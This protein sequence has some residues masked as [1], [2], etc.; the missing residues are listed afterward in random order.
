MKKWEGYQRAIEENLLIVDKNQQEVP[1]KLNPAQLDF[2]KRSTD[3]NVI[4]KARKMGFSSVLLAVAVIKFIFGKNERC[5]SMSFDQGASGKQLERAK[6]FLDSYQRVNKVDFKLKYNSKY[7]MVMEV[8]NGDDSYTNT[9]RVGTA[10]SSGFGRGDDITFLHLTEVS[11]ADNIELLLAGVGEAVVNNAMIT[12]ETTA[13]G[14]NAFKT[15]WD[16]SAAKQRNYKAMFYAP[17]W[18]YSQEYLDKKKAE[19]GRLFDQEYPA[20]PELAFLTSGNTYFDLEALKW[21]MQNSQ[22][23]LYV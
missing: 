20:N 7:E 6:R 5:V 11:M 21:H 13:N 2:L 23:P 1:F 14:Y 16:E 18:E 19:L 10:K 22:E 4:L 12:M 8:K 3:R 17:K 9:L 15:F